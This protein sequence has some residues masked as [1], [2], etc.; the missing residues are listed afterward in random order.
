[1][2]SP[3]ELSGNWTGFDANVSGVQKYEYALRRQSDSYYWSVCSGAGVWQVG[4]MWC[5]NSTSTTFTQSNLN[6]AT[7]VTYYV[8]V[9]TTDNAGNI[10]TAV[11]SNGQQVLP[12]LSFSL[13]GNTV[14]FNNLNATNSYTDTKTI[15]TTTSTN[16]ANGYTIKVY[17]T[18]NLRSTGVPTATIPDFSGTWST[19]A[20]WSGGQYGFG[21]TSNDTSVQGSNRFSSGTAF[22]AFSQTPPGDVVA[23]H[24]T[25]ID[26]STGSV[27]SEQFTITYKVAA[28]T[29]QDALYYQTSSIFIVTANY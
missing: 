16:A 6:L 19:P 8:S 26:G 17:N 28:S 21:Y 13:S 3:T 27:S 12:L 20:T 4:E 23:D 7:G 22:A 2:N 25:A 24:T 11:D 5:D 15:V 10:E 14:A 1:M 29:D 18:D 9:K